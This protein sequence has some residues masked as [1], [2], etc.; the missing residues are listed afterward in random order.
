MIT[1]QDYPF[2]S[3]IDLVDTI[4]DLIKNKIFCD[5]GCGCG[6]LLEYAITKDY[7]K[8]V[9]GLEQY[10]PFYD[11]AIE[12]GRHY[13]KLVD[14]ATKN[15]IPDA[16]VYYIW[17]SKVLFETIS[18]ALSPNKILICGIDG[19]KCPFVV[20]PNYLTFLESRTFEYNE[21]RWSKKEYD[22]WPIVGKRTIW[23]YVTTNNESA[24]QKI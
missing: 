5:I 6:D 1:L 19:G 11:T 20:L 17:T 4:S 8:N 24:I 15:A 18:K 23:I 12:N 14:V 10:K 3:P 13:I 16:D 2:R 7:T 21:T 9:I 22:G